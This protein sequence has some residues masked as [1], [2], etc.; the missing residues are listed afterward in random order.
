MRDKFVSI[1]LKYEKD[2]YRWYA[3]ELSKQYLFLV[4]HEG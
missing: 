1:Q 2:I 3:K 4:S